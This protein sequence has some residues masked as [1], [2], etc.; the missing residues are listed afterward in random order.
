MIDMPASAALR[1]IHRVALGDLVHR[2]ALKFPERTAI[3]DGATRL[4]H[5][6]LD[7]RSSRFAH[8]LIA[9]LGQG[10]QIG[11]L[12]ANSTDMVVAY[13]GI[14]KSGNVWVPVNIRLDVAAIDYILRHAEVSAVVVDEAFHAAPGVAEMLTRLGVP[15]IVTMAMQTTSAI[16]GA[17]TLTQAEQGQRAELPAIDID[18]HAPALIMYTSGTTGHPKGAVHSHVSV[19]TAL[20]GNMAGLAMTEQDVFSGVLPLFHCAQHCLAAAVHAAGGCVVLLRG[21]VPDEVRASIKAEKYTVFTGLPMMY[22]ALLA[23]PQFRCDDTLR[24]CIYAMAP[25]PKSLI[26]QIAAR[27]S[28]NVQLATGQTEMYPGTMTFKPLAHPELDANYWGI[29]LPHNETAVMDDE[30]NL[31][32]EGQPGE[33]VHRGANAML[34]YLK[35]PAA[36]AA[37]AEVRLAPHR[38]SGPVGAGQAAAV[39]GSQEGHDQDWWR[40]RGQRQGRGRGAGAPGRGR[41]GGAGP[42]A[43]ALVRGGVR[44]RGEEARDRAGRGGAAGALPPAAGR[45]R[46]A[47]AD[48]LRRSAA[49]HLDRQGAKAPAAPAVCRPGRQGL[50][51]VRWAR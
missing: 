32:G 20:M 13:S 8:H 51:C 47:Q 5:G 38:R 26:P 2:S 25:I 30:G 4:S 6:E 28:A 29:S 3:V 48:P 22:A 18:G 21:F 41:R 16:A 33:I 35:D 46:G 9:K 11:M 43:P 50:R 49:R 17:V 31:L 15:L 1:R 19:A 27:M 10:K 39:P 14:H 34:G 40:E 44:L 42:A 24:L 23:D 37:G 7:A 36:T 12:C 45:L